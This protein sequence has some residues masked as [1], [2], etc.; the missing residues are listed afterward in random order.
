MEISRFSNME[1]PRVH[2]VLDSAGPEKDSLSNALPDV[3]FPVGSLGRHPG[4][5]ISELNGWPALSPV[6]GF[7]C[8]LAATRT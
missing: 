1:C 3:A 6:N 2:R 7:T 8:S 4:W 5:V